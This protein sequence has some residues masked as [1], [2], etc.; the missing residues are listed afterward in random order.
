MSSTRPLPC[1]ARTVAPT[2]PRVKDHYA[3]FVAAV[4]TG[5]KAGSDFAEY[6]GPLTELAMIGIIAMKF[7]GR[8]LAWDGAAGRFTDCEDANRHLETPYRKG[9]TL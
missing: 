2:I 1:Q 8:K 5:R 3:D 7:P 6:G 4:R 9:W